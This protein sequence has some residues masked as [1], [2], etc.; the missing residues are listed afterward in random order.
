MP[1]IEEYDFF[2]KVILPFC[3]HGGGGFGQSLTAIAKLADQSII[4][5]GLSFAAILPALAMQSQWYIV[6]LGGIVSRA[7]ILF[8]ELFIRKQNMN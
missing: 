3:S 2:D 6:A 7:L 1:K 5:P 4:L 8:G